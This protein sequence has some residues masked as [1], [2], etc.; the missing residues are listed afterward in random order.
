MVGYFSGGGSIT[1]QSCANRV[2]GRRLF[3]PD[4]LAAVSFLI[5]LEEEDD[6]H[7]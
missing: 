6:V 7:P 1:T 4:A 3:G 5:P 2:P